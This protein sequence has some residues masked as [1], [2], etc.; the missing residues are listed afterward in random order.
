MSGRKNFF[1]HFPC[2]CYNVVIK[3]RGKKKKR[4]V[5]MKRIFSCLL[6]VVMTVG[7][8][9]IPIQAAEFSDVPE[10]HWAHDAVDYV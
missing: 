3:P 4:G 10:D 7:L 9:T 6:A 8:L 5:A 2:L 1:S